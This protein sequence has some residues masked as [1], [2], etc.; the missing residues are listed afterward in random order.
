MSSDISRLSPGASVHPL[1]VLVLSVLSLGYI[2]S[3]VNLSLNSNVPCLCLPLSIIIL[4][5]T[6]HSLSSIISPLNWSRL[7][8]RLETSERKIKY[9]SRLVALADSLAAGYLTPAH[10]HLQRL[11]T[12]HHTHHHLHSNTTTQ[13]HRYNITNTTTTPAS[14]TAPMPPWPHHQNTPSSPS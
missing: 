12:T 9:L 1:S 7:S 10:R 6:P 13:H 2:V 8:S 14:T 5:S 4:H 3:V 11:N